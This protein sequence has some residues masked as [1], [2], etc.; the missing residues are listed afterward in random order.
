[1][2][3]LWQG[4]FARH[5]PMSKR[6][7]LSPEPSGP[8]ATSPERLLAAAAAVIVVMPVCLLDWSGS[9]VSEPPFPPRAY[10]K[11]GSAM[12]MKIL[13]RGDDPD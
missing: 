4:V 7:M 3:L 13:T 1:M 5:R 9:I 12:I 6:G 8:L 11:L 2:L 10:R